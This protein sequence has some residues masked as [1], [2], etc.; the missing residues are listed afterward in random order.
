MADLHDSANGKRHFESH[1]MNISLQHCFN[2]IYTV[3]TK[4]NKP[5]ALI[6]KLYMNNIYRKKPR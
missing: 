2:T 4:N 3:T 6:M 1:F 5:T